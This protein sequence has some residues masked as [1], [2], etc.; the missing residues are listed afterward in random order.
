[1]L[2]GSGTGCRATC[3]RARLPSGRT[4]SETPFRPSSSCPATA[5][6]P[7]VQTAN[8]STLY[9]KLPRSVSESVQALGRQEG[10]TVFMTL[11]AAFYALLYRYT[12]HTDICVGTPSPTAA[13]PSSSR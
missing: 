8:G 6:G 10:A 11:L 2:S 3:C 12:G 4:S 13:R 9:T 7:A 1:M 5:R